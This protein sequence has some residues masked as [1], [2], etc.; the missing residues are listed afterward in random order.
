MRILCIDKASPT[1]EAAWSLTDGAALTWRA[2]RRAAVARVSNIGRTCLMLASLTL[3]AMA[4]PSMRETPSVRPR[5][6]RA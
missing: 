3:T 5:A 2:C 1:A 4:T 6:S